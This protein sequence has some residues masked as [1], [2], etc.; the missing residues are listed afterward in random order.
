MD[1]AT[2]DARLGRPPSR[3]CTL[4]RASDQSAVTRI[5]SSRPRPAC[6]TLLL[7]SS[8]T[9]SWASK[10]SESGS[11]SRLRAR[12]AL[13]G[14]VR[15]ARR[16]KSRRRG[17]SGAV[18]WW[19]LATVTTFPCRAVAGKEECSLPRSWPISDTDPRP[20]RPASPRQDP[21][22][23]ATPWYASSERRRVQRPCTDRR[24]G[25]LSGGMPGHAPPANYPG[26][27][28]RPLLARPSLG[29]SSLGDRERQGGEGGGRCGFGVAGRTQTI[30]GEPD[31]PWEY[32]GAA[33]R[34]RSGRVC[35][36][37]GLVGAWQPG[38][39]R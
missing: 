2:G 12:R 33:M 36:L 25:C 14:A 10:A 27:G 31:R 6:R 34:L 24:Q 3:T 11:R 26:A 13:R 16:R 37:G 1:P 22:G 32:G 20:L 39:G 29:S 17:V 5:R 9:S 23:C 15:V 18:C 21:G 8:E 35:L 4:S 7:T 28:C 38:Q 30:S 19:C